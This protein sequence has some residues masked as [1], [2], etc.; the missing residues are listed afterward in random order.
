TSSYAPYAQ[1]VIDELHLLVGA[2]R[3]ARVDF[4]MAGMVL[5]VTPDYFDRFPFYDGNTETDRLL[6]KIDY[7]FIRTGGEWWVPNVAYDAILT[8]PYLGFRPDAR[9]IVLVVTDIVPQTI[10]GA[11]WYTISCTNATATAVEKF[12]ESDGIEI[13]YAKNPA[14]HPNFTGYCDSEINPRACGGNPDWGIGGSRLT[15]LR[16]GLGQQAVQLNWPLDASDFYIKLGVNPQLPVLDSKYY[17]LWETNFTFY[18]PITMAGYEDDYELRIEIAAQDP[19]NAGLSLTNSFSVDLLETE[20]DLSLNIT[21]EIG[22]FA[23]DELCADIYHDMAGRQ[24]GIRYGYCPVDGVLNEYD[25][26]AGSYV[27]HVFDGGKQF[28][29]IDTLRA[30]DYVSFEMPD[31]PYSLATRVPAGDYLSDKYKMLGV[32]QD[33]DDWRLSGDPF[34]KFAEQ[35]REWLLKVETSDGGVS[36]EEMVALRRMNIA[37]SGYANLTEYAQFEAQRAVKDFQMIIKRIGEVIAE[38]KAM[39]KG[40][41]R[42]WKKELAAGAIKVLLNALSQGRVGSLI[43]VIEE[44][45]AELAKWAAGEGIEEILNR[46]IYE[47]DQLGGPAGTM[48]KYVRILSDMY[49]SFK[50]DDH[51]GNRD[52]L[53]EAAQEI[54]LD[55]ALRLTRHTIKTYMI[56]RAFDEL[57]LDNPLAIAI[58][59]LVKEIVDAA[60]TPDGFDNFSDRMENWAN[61]VGVE[62]YDHNREELLAATN[63]IFD[64]LDAALEGK[65]AKVGRDFLLGFLRDM[66][67]A[68]IPVVKNGKIVHKFDSNLIVESLVHHGVY[69][70]VLRSF[71]VD[72]I[73]RGLNGAL[74]QA[75]LYS[76]NGPPIGAVRWEWETEMRSDFSEYRAVVEAMQSEAWT[77]LTAQEIIDNWAM[78]LAKLV[79][80]LGPISDALDFIVYIYPPLQDTAE[81]VHGLMAVLDGMQVLAHSIDFGLKIK[82]LETLGDQAEVLYQTAF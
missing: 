70:I 21:D 50:D 58:K 23:N 38:I 63:E 16:W 27:M 60:L 17:L 33:L 59:E 47:F 57:D 44:G 80:L 69:N 28:Y 49:F 52:K 30:Q 22:G 36:W 54:G 34:K 42:N 1:G 29:T 35:A 37:L 39:N 68:N 40:L 5:D 31:E 43:T 10:Y 76:T 2:L 13:Y 45:V 12:A 7:W 56:E 32:L 62:L 8:T 41:E 73:Q 11:F 20:H 18:D 53:W 14:D 67:I 78:G 71:F 61:R 9:K 81:A 65:I 79:G 55:L 77:A 82:C 72:E 64:R 48:A 26:A 75:K 19:V 4:R 51:A 74:D 3:T 25:L 24:T 6:E 15:D 46:I 66:A